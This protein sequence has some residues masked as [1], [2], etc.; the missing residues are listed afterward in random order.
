MA[1]TGQSSRVKEVPK[2]TSKN[3]Q[4]TSKKKSSEPALSVKS[5]IT[6]TRKA[7]PAKSAEPEH[8]P[9]PTP[10]SNN[11]SIAMRTLSSDQHG[12]IH[13]PR[14][15]LRDR[16][17]VIDPKCLEINSQHLDNLA[18]SA[19]P[20][21]PRTRRP[22]TKQVVDHHDDPP[23]PDDRIELLDVKHHIL[24]SYM[25]LLTTDS[26]ELDFAYA[27]LRSTDEAWRRLVELYL[28]CERLV[29]EVSMRLV[30]DAVR[31]HVEIEFPSEEG[32]GFVYERTQ[33]GEG[34]EEGGN[35]LRGILVD[36]VLMG[37]GD[38]EVMGLVLGRVGLGLRA[39]REDVV[40]RL[41]EGRGCIFAKA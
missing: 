17:F 1:R 9:S 19:A 36:Q 15:L 31:E 40:R 12:T 23:P 28:L 32:V 16:S 22:T 5:K 26:I 37:W 3:R 25:L 38:G 2:R 20:S 21:V 29:D 39:L 30:G 7:P 35:V 8:L 18:A 4:S 13:L 14:Q 41:V 27:P 11:S 10:D 24:S 34:G 33:G 6:K